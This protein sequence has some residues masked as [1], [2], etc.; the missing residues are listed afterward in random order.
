[1]MQTNKHGQGPPMMTKNIGSSMNSQ[2]PMPHSHYKHKTMTDHTLS[3]KSE[4]KKV[5]NTQTPNRDHA[6]S[7]D[8]SSS[9]LTRKF[10]LFQIWS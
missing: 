6:L 9:F 2:S 1:M 10:V 5:S 4:L 8:G 7:D 3:Q